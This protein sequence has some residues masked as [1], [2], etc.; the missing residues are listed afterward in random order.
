MTRKELATLTE[1]AKALVAA[2]AGCAHIVI[3]DGADPT[4][5]DVQTLDAAMRTALDLI[6]SVIAPRL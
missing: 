6:S 5:K 3:T 4:F 2:R 1:A